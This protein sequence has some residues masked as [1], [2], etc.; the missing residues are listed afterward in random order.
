MVNDF[1]LSYLLAKSQALR[2][3]SDYD[4]DDSDHSSVEMLTMDDPD[5]GS[6]SGLNDAITN[7]VSAGYVPPS[8][9]VPSTYP[10]SL[11]D[12]TYPSP[13]SPDNFV[14]NSNDTPFGS[15]EV[16]IIKVRSPKLNAAEESR[17]SRRSTL[18]LMMIAPKGM[19]ITWR[20]VCTRQDFGWTTRVKNQE[21]QSNQDAQ[22]SQEERDETECPV[23]TG[24]APRNADGIPREPKWQGG[25]IHN[26]F[27]TKHE[28]AN[29]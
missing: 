22:S 17:L 12:L 28:R 19:I 2:A 21:Q 23:K 27:P 6:K 3:N 15:T 8:I 29:E 26:N 4:D 9:T 7:K 25:P 20:E 5:A 18:T 24:W 13:G 10:V 1:V 11:H 16:F 14:V